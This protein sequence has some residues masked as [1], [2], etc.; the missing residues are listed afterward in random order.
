MLRARREPLDSCFSCGVVTSAVVWVHNWFSA[1]QGL[2]GFLT[3]RTRTGKT[4]AIP[5]GLP[6][7]VYVRLRLFLD[8]SDHVAIV[9]ISREYVEFSEVVLDHW[10][11]EEEPPPYDIPRPAIT[12]RA[13]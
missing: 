4:E 3:A 11:P 10:Q 9:S 7:H 12:H 8:R 6:P 13:T 1:K 5:A 2:S